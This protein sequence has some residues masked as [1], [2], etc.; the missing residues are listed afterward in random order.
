MQPPQGTESSWASAC[1][2]CLPAGHC[3]GDPS[4]W[5]AVRRCPSVKRLLEKDSTLLL[6]YVV[7]Q[8]IILKPDREAKY[9]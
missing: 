9:G 2:L 6:S 4:L 7:K 1:L 8:K 3:R 5:A